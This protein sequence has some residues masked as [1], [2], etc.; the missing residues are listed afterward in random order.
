MVTSDRPYIICHMMSTI[1]GKIASGIKGVDIL[2][3]D[4]FGLYLQIESALKGQA[5]MCGRVTMEMFASGVDTP[6][7]DLN[8]HIDD[9]D[10]IAPNKEK[11][12]VVATD[13]NGH[14]RWGKNTIT[15]TN[16][17]GDN[18]LVVVVTHQTHQKYLTYLQ[19]KEI[20]Y[21]FGG[22][23]GIDFELV[24]Q[25]LKEKLNIDKLL[26]EGGG[27]LNGSVLAAD[28]IDEISLLITP[29]AL[30][31]SN[32]P[33]VFDRKTTEELNV[34]KYKLFEVK[35]MEKDTVWLRYRRL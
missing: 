31:R 29:L 18:H 3:K 2:D 35:P 30:N 14:L 20:S 21:I 7:P 15:L 6:L 24:F 27:L 11:S 8:K 23:D 13:T 28:F 1:D 16:I 25:K 5:W 32:A 34:K 9:A 10:Y 33:S 22:K 12:Y 19:S 26:L 4:Y 17:P